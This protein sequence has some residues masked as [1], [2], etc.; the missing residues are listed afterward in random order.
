M[1]NAWMLFFC[2]CLMAV[3]VSPS[4]AGYRV[5]SQGHVTVLVEDPAHNLLG[6]RTYAAGSTIEADTMWTGPF[7][8]WFSL[9]LDSP[10]A[11]LFENV[12]LLSH[13]GETIWVSSNADDPDYS[14]FVQ[15]LKDGRNDNVWG[16][17]AIS[18]AADFAGAGGLGYFEASYFDGGAHDFAGMNIGRIGLRI[19]GAS[20]VQ[21]AADLPEPGAFVSLLCGVVG[22]CGLVARRR[23]RR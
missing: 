15:G 23:D 2:M 22:M 4:Q 11:A 20:V 5:T 14:T 3:V 13:I 10:Y 16:S 17:F 19:D 8:E 7:G 1:R 21:E 18:S 9:G 12:P 6:S